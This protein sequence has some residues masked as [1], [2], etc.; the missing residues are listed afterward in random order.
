MTNGCKL[1]QVAKEQKIEKPWR[2]ELLTEFIKTNKF[3]RFAEVG[4]WKG[5]NAKHMLEILPKN[6]YEY[7]FMIDR[8]LDAIFAQ[9]VLDNQYFRAPYIKGQSVDVAKMFADGYFDLIFID[10]DHSYKSCYDD[11]KAWL[12][13]VRKGGILAG[14]DYMHPLEG[15]KVGVKKAVDEL[16]GDKVN[17]KPEPLKVHNWWVE[18]K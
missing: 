10:A 4:V 7:F 13:K 17:I 12:P 16:F 15:T 5:E 9:W 11:I 8:G 1:C 18:I 14:H 3:T 6:S 2:W